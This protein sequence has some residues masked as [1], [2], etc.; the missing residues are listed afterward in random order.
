MIFEA[1]SAIFGKRM[2]HLTD[3]NSYLIKFP[4]QQMYGIP[5]PSIPLQQCKALLQLVQEA[6]DGCHP[7]GFQRGV[8]HSKKSSYT[9]KI[10]KK[11][12]DFFEDLKSFTLFGSEQTLDFNV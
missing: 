4:P 2:L 3:R 6:R 7:H 10:Q 11:N 12:K 8:V 5:R 1:F 9:K